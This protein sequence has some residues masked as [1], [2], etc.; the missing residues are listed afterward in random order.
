MQAALFNRKTFRFV[1]L[2]KA[3]Q[4]NGRNRFSFKVILEK[5]KKL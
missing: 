2:C 5:A 4:T 1:T 3:K